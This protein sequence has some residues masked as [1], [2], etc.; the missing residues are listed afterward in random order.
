M[1]EKILDML[2]EICDDEIV[3]EDL[4]VELF[5]SGLIDSLSFTELLVTIEE[6][7][8]IV[9]SPSEIDRSQIDTPNKIIAMIKERVGNEN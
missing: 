2:E 4:D 7:F 5:K 3:K 6:N 9:I 1:D 8:G